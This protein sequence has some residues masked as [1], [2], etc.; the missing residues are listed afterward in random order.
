MSN[1][2]R[3]PRLD[4]DAR[5]EQILQV[6]A[7][8][9]AHAGHKAVSVRTIAADAGVTRA[10]VYH[11]FQGREQLLEAVLHREAQTLLDITQPDPALSRHENLRRAVG[12]YLERFSES[13]GALRD[14]YA[15]SATAPSLARQLAARNHAVQVERIL[16]YLEQED[17]PLARLA[18]AAWLG[19]VFQAAQESTESPTVSADEV[20]RLCVHAL[21]AVTGS[22]LDIGPQGSVTR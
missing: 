5:R 12:L 21:H 6:A 13:S 15:P 20:A 19:F 17:T 4:P 8:H 16:G 2:N 9:F 18:I 14:L 11:Y 3:Y 10:L 22:A 1:S 7:E